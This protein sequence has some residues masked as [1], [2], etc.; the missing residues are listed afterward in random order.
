MAQPNQTG[1]NYDSNITSADVASRM[2]REGENF[3]KT[4]DAEGGIDTTSGYT[5]DREGKLNNFAV[6]PEMYINEPGDLREK[7]KAEAASRVETLKEVNQTGED[8]KLSM[9][10]DERGKGTGII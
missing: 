2:E 10:E 8:G 7:E 6:E 4:P 5:V 9:S 3:K 1:A